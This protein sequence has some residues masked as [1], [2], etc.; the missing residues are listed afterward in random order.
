[1][2]DTLASSSG[3]DEMLSA[4][5]FNMDHS[6]SLRGTSI[7][8]FTVNPIGCLVAAFRQLL[9]TRRLKTLPAAS[10]CADLT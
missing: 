3:L 5:A 6:S 7:F 4:A 9:R 1:M 2:S 10:F 8:I